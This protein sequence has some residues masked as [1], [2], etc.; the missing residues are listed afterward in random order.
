MASPNSD[1]LQPYNS[2]PVAHCGPSPNFPLA[3]SKEKL[4]DQRD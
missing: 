2:D 3:I 4:D 1:G